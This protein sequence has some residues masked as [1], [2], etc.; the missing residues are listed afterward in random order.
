M[1]SEWGSVSYLYPTWK[2]FY[3]NHLGKW[4]YDMGEL[5]IFADHNTAKDSFVG[6]SN[7]KEQIKVHFNYNVGA[8]GYYGLESEILEYTYV[9]IQTDGKWLINEILYEQ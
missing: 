5:F 1:L 9:L 6:A 2:D 4:G 7:E 8:D 3:E